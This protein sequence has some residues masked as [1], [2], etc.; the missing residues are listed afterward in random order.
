MTD[1]KIDSFVPLGK[2]TILAKIALT[3]RIATINRA[4]YLSL[5]T[6]VQGDLSPLYDY[7]LDNALWRG[8]GQRT[9]QA[10]A[11]VM[12]MDLRGLR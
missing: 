2:L 3:P 9:A 5:D 1:R 10:N 7:P 4:L 8:L 11:Q 12:L 6:M